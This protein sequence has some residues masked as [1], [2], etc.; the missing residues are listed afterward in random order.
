MGFFT[1]GISYDCLGLGCLAAS[2]IITRLG[3]GKSMIVG[4]VFDFLWIFAQLIP[5]LKETHPEIEIYNFSYTFIVTTNFLAATFSG[6]AAGLLWVA[7]GRY[8]ADCA[9]DTTSGF[10]FGYF[11]A[12]YMASQVFGNL[13]A[14]FVFGQYSISSFYLIMMSFSCVA[15][16]MFYMLG[17]PV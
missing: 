5:A 2:P 17:T 15:A 14:A 8:I 4:C 12:W 13:F 3:F 16:M 7:G 11:W 9:T 1:L 10:Y 6:L